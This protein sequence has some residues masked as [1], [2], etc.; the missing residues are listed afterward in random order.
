MARPLRIQYPGA[1]YHVTSRGNERRAIVRDDK[2][3]WL[4]IRILE[5]TVET[6]GVVIHAWIL[7]DNHY[8]LLVETP[9]ANLSQAIRHL[10]GI[11]TMR[12]N[13][14]HGRTGHLFQG[15]YKA[16]L[17]DK[18]IYLMELSRYV[19]LNPVRAKIV[20][21]PREWKWG[22]YRATAGYEET[23]AWLETRWLL[24]QFHSARHKAQER[25]RQFVM[26]GLKQKE[27]PWDKL[28]SQILLGKEEFAEHIRGKM[29]GKHH[30]EAPRRQ[31]E[32]GL[33]KAQEIL[34]KAAKTYGVKVRD[35][36]VPARRVNEGRDVGIWA[37]RQA[38]R[39]S[40]DK[41]GKIMGVKYSAVSHAVARMKKKI[42]EDKKF[43]RKVRN[44]VT[45]T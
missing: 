14:K 1:F 26:E 7:M 18:N 21:H 25:Y 12:F 23:P 3:R 30:E 45:K 20:K 29:R 42:R 16:I 43:E 39:L 4:F 33:P 34:E 13:R 11:Y 15:R 8:H 32:L 35:I 2:D 9:E 27:S 41:I 37:L 22:S 31:Q 38:C 28:T 24:E 44:A 19:V 36:V 5:D 10:N 17:V 40:L 6:F